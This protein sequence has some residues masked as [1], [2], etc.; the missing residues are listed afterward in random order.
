MQR[1]RHNH[2]WKALSQH[3]L[4]GLP[5]RRRK[6][7]STDR[8]LR[9]RPHSKNTRGTGRHEALI[10][11]TAEWGADISPTPHRWHSLHA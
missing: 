7:A 1:S 8:V 3:V 4:L 2:G 5:D 9:Y 10:T 11:T 6:T